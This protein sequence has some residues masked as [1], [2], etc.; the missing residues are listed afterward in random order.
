MWR[1]PRDSSRRG[2]HQVIHSSRVAQSIPAG[3]GT[4]TLLGNNPA[5]ARFATHTNLADIMAPS[6][7]PTSTNRRKVVSR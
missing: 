1:R 5:Y 4:H 2:E 3:G 6:E 7:C